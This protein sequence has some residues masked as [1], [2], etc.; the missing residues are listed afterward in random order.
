MGT[1]SFNYLTVLFIK[2]QSVYL[3][4]FCPLSRKE[5]NLLCELCDSSE[6]ARGLPAF[7]GQIKRAVKKT[8]SLTRKA[9]LGLTA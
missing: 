5:K 6:S 8:L 2:D 4:L 1:F 7:G 9:K 3:F